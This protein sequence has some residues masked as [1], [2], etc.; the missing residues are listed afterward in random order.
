MLLILYIFALA[1]TSLIYSAIFIFNFSWELLLN[2]Y[3]IPFFRMDVAT[4]ND[5]DSE[6]R[7]TMWLFFAE[8]L[9]KLLLSDDLQYHTPLEVF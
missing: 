1:L 3:S 8:L 4:G 2:S 7:R 6:D 5:A 9:I